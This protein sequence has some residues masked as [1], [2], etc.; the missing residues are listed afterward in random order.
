MPKLN[1][2]LHI[3]LVSWSIQLGIHVSHDCR[4][5]CSSLG[6]NLI[7]LLTATFLPPFL[8]EKLLHSDHERGDLKQSEMAPSALDSEN[9]A[10]RARKTKN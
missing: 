4:S 6:A 10:Q 8:E 5:T 7:H 2:T 1:T 9:T 3:Q